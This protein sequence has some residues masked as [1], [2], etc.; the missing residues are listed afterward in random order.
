MPLHREIRR[1][2]EGRKGG[3]NMA[4]EVEQENALFTIQNLTKKYRTREG[5]IFTNLLS[6][7]NFMKAVDDVNIEIE[8][9][10]MIGLA[11]QSGCGKSTLGELFLG[12]REPSKGTIRY[13]GHDVADFNKEELKA[14]RNDCQV[15]FQDPYESL[16]PRFTVGRTVAEPLR[17][18]D[19]GDPEEREER[20][21]RALEE[22]GL[23]P[24]GEFLS[25][26]PSELSGGQRQRVSIA[27]ALVL[28]PS[29]IVADEPVSMLDVSVSTGI[30]NQFK[31]L[32][33]ER[34]LTILYIS[35]DLATINYLTDRTMIMYL[36]N[37]VEDGPTEEVIKN[38][39]HPYTEQLI[40]AVPDPN[41]ETGREG[42]H[43]TGISGTTDLPTGCRFRP[44]CKYATEECGQSEPPLEPIA[45]EHE[46]ACYH[47]TNQ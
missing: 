33:Q 5:G 7:P 12:L 1:V 47:P 27:R 6:E 29:F 36:G 19:M 15:I 28:D 38:P 23:M 24:G 46:T 44:H 11:G 30:L 32:Q 43:M 18:H 17:I 8:K 37:I 25:M 2:Q 3:G 21:I 26:L 16:N 14:F 13:K 9:G 45:D 41:Q 20:A 10:E 35:H 34:N 39:A 22:A 42:T 31:K 4:D 40:S